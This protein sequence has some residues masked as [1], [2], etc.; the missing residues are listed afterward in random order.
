VVHIGVVR[1]QI[2]LK[3][4]KGRRRGRSKEKEEEVTEEKPKRQGGDRQTDLSEL[5]EFHRDIERDGDEDI[6]EDQIGE[7]VEGGF[8]GVGGV[9]PLVGQIPVIHSPITLEKEKRKER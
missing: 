9:L 1:N 3:K 4:K 8:G 2:G 6:E 7:E 5:D